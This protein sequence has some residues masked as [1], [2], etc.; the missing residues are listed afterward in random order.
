MSQKRL[1]LGEKKKVESLKFCFFAHFRPL[2]KRQFFFFNLIKNIDMNK[3]NKFV[4]STL[5]AAAAM[6]STAWAEGTEETTPV[7][8]TLT[9]N[10]SAKEGDEGFG[11]TTFATVDAAVKVAQSAAG[12]IIDLGTLS[13]PADFPLRNDDST[14]WRTNGCYTFT[15]GNYGDLFSW[16]QT[17]KPSEASGVDIDITFDEAKIVVGKFR[18]DNGASLTIADSHLDSRGYLSDNRGWTTF[19]GDSTINIKNSVV[20]YHAKD[21][22]TDGRDAD[23]RNIVAGDKT[24]DYSSYDA[25]M[26][27]GGSGVMTVENSTIFAFTEGINGYGAL[28]VMDRGLMEFKD[29]AVYAHSFTV[30]KSNSNATVGR[31]GEVATMILNNSVLKSIN[32]DAPYS[33]TV[34]GEVAGALI[35]ENNAE[36]DHGAAMTVN[37]NGS[38]SVSDSSLKVGSITNNGTINITDSTFVAN[39][40]KG[41]SYTTGDA[42]DGIYI[43]GKS[44]IKGTFDDANLKFRVGQ[45][46]NGTTNTS[47]VAD[48]KLHHDVT[49]DSSKISVAFA[50]FYDAKVTFTSDTELTMNKGYLMTSFAELNVAEGKT[51]TVNG[52]AVIDGATVFGTGNYCFTGAQFNTQDNNW[53]NSVVTVAKGATLEHT[54]ASG[55]GV[56]ENMTVEGTVNV[57]KSTV[58]VGYSQRGF[59]DGA[60]LKIDGG[61]FTASANAVIYGEKY[62]D[63][64]NEDGEVGYGPVEDHVGQIYE[65]TLEV[66][67]GAT[68]TFGG[69]ITNNG[70]IE[71]GEGSTLTASVI[72]GTGDIVLAGTLNV[73]SLKADELTIVVGDAGALVTQAAVML[74]AEGE[75]ESSVSVNKLTVVADNAEGLDLSTIL[76]SKVGADMAGVIEN[77]IANESSP[78]EFVLQDSKGLEYTVTTDANGNVKVGALTPEPS[79]FGLLAGLGA[80]ALAVSRRRRNRR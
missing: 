30:G 31:D 16:I 21:N 51:L 65:S 34:G 47:P 36:I 37:S 44:S 15:G 32:G 66:I 28:G 2:T 6:T 18:L 27:F 79:A 19:Y 78:V 57:S 46:W 80:I 4:L 58:L 24:K 73:G 56:Y 5:V 70:T 43:N 77:S 7:L 17:P 10:S 76:S 39:T 67:N 48:G 68:A 45:T 11:V 23:S 20:G 61:T 72:T 40:V 12:A 59:S 13:R 52:K 42:S 63:A 54:G 55:F 29:S 53:K 35:L 22:A 3:M 64:A 9:V 69:T 49:I 50:Q 71:V 60:I 1:D 8:S 33:L 41:N 26:V 75:S 14:L 38:V 62:D 74:L 25:G